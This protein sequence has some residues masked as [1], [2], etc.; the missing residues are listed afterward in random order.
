[1]S[2]RW[3]KLDASLRA[4]GRN[5]STS[6]VARRVIAVAGEALEQRRSSR[7][8]ATSTPPENNCP[9]DIRKSE[10]AAG[11]PRPRFAMPF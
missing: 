10:S 11:T 3:R 7:E 8:S 9:I 5:R 6:Y 4:S 2:S 1:M